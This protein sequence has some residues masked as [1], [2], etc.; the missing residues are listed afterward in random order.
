MKKAK[1]YF[2]IELPNKK[3]VEK[4][5]QIFAFNDITVNVLDLLGISPYMLV[6]SKTDKNIQFEL[7][8]KVENY[9]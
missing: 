5:L 4:C 7:M 9:F 6:P 8:E 2:G 3:S 1:S